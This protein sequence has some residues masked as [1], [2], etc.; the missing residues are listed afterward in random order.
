MAL[1]LV[2]GGCG[3]IG[4]HLCEALIEQGDDVRVLDDLSTG[5]MEN[6]PPKI[7][8]LRGSVG[9]LETVN[10]AMRDVAGCY[11][12]AA[13]A[14]VEQSSR[15]WF[16]AHRT[17]LSGAIAIFDAARR[18][19][20]EKPIPVV[21]A[22]SAAV[23][24]DSNGLPLRESTPVR[25]RSP[26]GADKYGCELHARIATEIFGIP[27]IGLRFFNVFGPR[28][29]PNSPY[30]GV[31]SIFCDRVLKRQPLDIFGDGLQ[32]RDFIFVGDV[33]MALVA[34][35]KKVPKGATVIN[36][37]TGRPTSI[38]KLA[39]LISTVYN[40][41]PEIS[42]GPA[43][44]GEIHQSWGDRSLM[45]Q[46]LGMGPSTALRAGLKITLDWMQTREFNC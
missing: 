1:Y 13:V 5:R 39:R 32:T 18:F 46:I 23:Y 17:N 24:G 25:P 40:Y 15:D 36:V 35:M 4:S 20:K 12:L 43:R 19:G 10:A 26:Y 28:Q 2:T 6:L 9:N 27:T 34:T 30:S 42:F 38:L 31:I 29:T 7:E 22:S 3:F 21:Y 41:E 45:N 16:G 44:P 37:C 8:L 33:A 11:H 14:S